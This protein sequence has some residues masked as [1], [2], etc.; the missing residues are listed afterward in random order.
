MGFLGNSTDFLGFCPKF[1]IMIPIP[2]PWIWKI[3]IDS[4]NLKIDPNSNH[5]M[6]DCQVCRYGHT[7]FSSLCCRLHNV[8]WFGFRKDESGLSQTLSWKIVARKNGAHAESKPVMHPELRV[9]RPVV[10]PCMHLA[11]K[12]LRH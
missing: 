4:R 6:W 11:T 2:I 9:A 12:P 1:L 3:D 8:I 5:K 7:Y 10:E